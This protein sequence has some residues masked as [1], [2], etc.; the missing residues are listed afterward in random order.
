MVFLGR[1]QKNG[2]NAILRFQRFRITRSQTIIRK[3]FMRMRKETY[4]GMQLGKLRSPVVAL[5]LGT[6]LNMGPVEKM[7]FGVLLIVLW[8]RRE[9]RSLQM[10]RFLTWDLVLA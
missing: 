7:P 4:A 8:K 3:N 6:F 9:P 2:S 5:V 1:S 10:E